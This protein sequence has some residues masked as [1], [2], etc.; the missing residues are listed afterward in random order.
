MGWN[1]PR[2]TRIVLWFFGTIMSGNLASGAVGA[3]LKC[4]IGS[5]SKAQIKC[6]FFLLQFLAAFGKV[7]PELALRAM[8]SPSSQPMITS[9]VTFLLRCVL[10]ICNQTCK[11]GLHFPSNAFQ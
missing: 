10:H 9:T 11:L 6:H 1:R 8:C 5:N 4:C 3:D 2:G 7:P